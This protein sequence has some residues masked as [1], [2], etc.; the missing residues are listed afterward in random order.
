MKAH[1]RRAAS[2]EHDSAEP[3]SALLSLLERL[4]YQQGE[5]RLMLAVLTDVVGCIERYR[6]GH[7]PRSWPAFRTALSWVL[8]HDRAWPF[9]FEHICLALDLDPARLC[10]ILCAPLPPLLPVSRRDLGNRSAPHHR[11]PVQG[12]SPASRHRPGAHTQTAGPE[13]LCGI[14]IQDTMSA[15]SAGQFVISHNVHE[16]VT[17]CVQSTLGSA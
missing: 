4:H 2:F 13:T 1:A 7:G 10:S 14:K 17:I 5:K 8:S 12:L 3:Q 6:S 16:I 9:S 15:I 11:P